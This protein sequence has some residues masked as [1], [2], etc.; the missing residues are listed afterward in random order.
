MRATPLA[1]HHAQVGGAPGTAVD[2]R[3][4][5]RP[6]TTGRTCTRTTGCT[7]PPAGQRAVLVALV[8]ALTT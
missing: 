7:S 8:R 5:T 2:T 3:E 6:A 1:R 4:A